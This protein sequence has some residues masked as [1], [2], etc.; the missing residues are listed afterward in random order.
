VF[1]LLIHK[2]ELDRFAVMILVFLIDALDEFFQVGQLLFF[3]LGHG[4]F[5]PESKF[6][7]A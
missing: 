5:F 1:S 6:N 3:F 2:G 7:T 4:R